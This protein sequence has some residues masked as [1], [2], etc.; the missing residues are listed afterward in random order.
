MG[1]LY[2]LQHVLPNVK[3]L[4]PLSA[5]SNLQRGSF[6]RTTEEPSIYCSR[7]LSTVSPILIYHLSLKNNIVIHWLMRIC[8][9][10]LA[11]LFCGVSVRIDKLRSWN[12]YRQTNSRR[13][14]RHLAL[15]NAVAGLPS[16]VLGCEKILHASLETKYTVGPIKSLLISLFLTFVSS[17][18]Q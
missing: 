5:Q 1:F 7:A 2:Q 9:A 15:P 13:E 17:Y 4:S 11:F 8:G 16:N 3:L 14:W 6:L 10:C 12:D 18:W